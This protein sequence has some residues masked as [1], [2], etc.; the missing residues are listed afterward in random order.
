MNVLAELQKRARTV[1]TPAT[2]ATQGRFSVVESQ[3]SQ[4]SQGV[5]VET[6]LCPAPAVDPAVRADMRAHL[7]G[8]ADR[9]GLPAV[10]VHRLHDADLRT[11]AE[12]PEAG[13]RAF[14][15]AA[16]DTATRRA[17]K[18]PEGDTAAIYCQHCGP[19]YAHPSIAA[20]LPMV[21]GWPR[22]L[23]CPWCAIRKVG[24]YVPRPP[25]PSGTCAYWKPDTVNPAAGMGTCACGMFYPMQRHRCGDYRPSG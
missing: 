19:V 16:A 3:E 25:I 11:L 13:L 4:E 8:L 20:V 2:P 1:A 12:L 9:L 10:L 5:K 22:A 18:P 15:L 14:L 6:A 7:L 23:G 17:G 21:D 24:G